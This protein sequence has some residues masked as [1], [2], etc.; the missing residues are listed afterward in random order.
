MIPL[1]ALTELSSIAEQLEQRGRFAEAAKVDAAAQHLANYFQRKQLHKELENGSSS[2]ASRAGSLGST[3]E[4]KKKSPRIEQKIEQ[5]KQQLELVWDV[6][7]EPPL[8][9]QLEQLS[10]QTPFELAKG[11]LEFALSGRVIW[12]DG[13]KFGCTIQLENDPGSQMVMTK[14]VQ[15]LELSQ[16]QA[17]VEKKPAGKLTIEGDGDDDVFRSIYVGGLE[18]E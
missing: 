18:P 4:F 8:S 11:R 2:L 7:F 6:T 10:Q 16:P 5:G 15:N 13:S 1:Q 3:M 9:E 17:V 12:C 14:A